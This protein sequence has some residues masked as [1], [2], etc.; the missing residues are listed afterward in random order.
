[1]Q[2]TKLRSIDRRVLELLVE[3]REDVFRLQAL[4]MRHEAL[5]LELEQSE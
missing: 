3:M 1:M 5:K 2:L 4:K